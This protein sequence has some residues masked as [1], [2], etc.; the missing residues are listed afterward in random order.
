MRQMLRR[1]APWRRAHV[2]GR[3]RVPS[4]LARVT[5]VR[6]V[7]FQFD[8]AWFT[9]VVS[10]VLHCAHRKS[11]AEIAVLLS[12]DET[13]RRLNRT[14]RG[15]DYATDVLSFSSDDTSP[16]RFIGDIALSVPRIINQADAYGHGLPR[17]AGYLLVHGT[18]HL[19]GHDHETDEDQRVMRVAEE[20]AL[21]IVGLGRP[22][23]STGA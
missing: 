13:L 8:D 17:E 14:Y 15:H 19:L 20:A 10:A 9:T 6:E 1:V 22:P 18:L 5:V 23:T 4:V 7:P 11:P 2:R 3:R 12:D 16:S 21:A